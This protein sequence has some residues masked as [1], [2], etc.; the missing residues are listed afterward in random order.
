MA[1]KRLGYEPYAWWLTREQ[2][3]L[4]LRKHYPVSQLPARLVTLVE[5]LEAVEGKQF[6]QTLVGEL[7][8]PLITP[9]ARDA[10]SA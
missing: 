8:A 4:C 10:Q 9:N 5:K 7:D 2:I 6:S 3:G 1:K